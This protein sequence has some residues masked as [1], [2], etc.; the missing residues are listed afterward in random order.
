[1]FASAKLAVSAGLHQVHISADEQWKQERVTVQSDP[2]DRKSTVTRTRLGHR[3]PGEISPGLDAVSH[4]LSDPGAAGRVAP[5]AGAAIM[6]LVLVLLPPTSS[7]RSMLTAAAVLTTIVIAAA[8]LVPWVRLPA[9]C[10]ATV[11]LGFFA[12]VALL[13]QSGGGA[14]SGYSPLVML[15]ILWLAIYGSR[16]QFRLGIAAT[17]VTFVVPQILVG[18]PLYP[19]TGWRGSVIWVTIG[20]LAGSATQKLVD[21]SR[22]RTADV[23]ALGA[24]TRT[25]SANSDPRPELCAAAQLVTGAAFTVLFEPHPDGTLVAT[26][27][28]DG[29][30]VGLRVDPRTHTCATAQAWRTR[31]RI[32][33][34]NAAIDP[35][36]SKLAEHTKARALLCQPVT[37]RGRT[38]ALLAVGF[39]ESHQHAPT[40]ALYLVD[41]LA[42][43]IGAAIDRADMVALLA[44]Q[45]RRDSLTGAANRRSWDEEMNRELAR[46]YR[47]GAPLTIVIIDIDHFKAY[48]DTYGHAAGDELLK[49]LVIA[50]R[51]ELRAGD[52]IARW[53]GEEFALALH[54]C[55]LQEAQTIASRLLSVVPGGQTVSI[56]LTQARAQ[57]TPQALFERADMALYTA[58]NGGRNQ[59]KAHESSP[60]PALF[61]G[62]GVCESAGQVAPVD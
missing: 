47:S 36:S 32:Y 52:V 40:S 56:G 17:A 49:D 30:N 33:L 20:L 9:W 1:M 31:T 16:T 12:V 29:V 43:E 38:K 50:I 13:R 62:H 11:P 54:D 21:A 59:V 48:N 10:Q 24:I 5:F 57:D 45:S 61:H 14:I 51:A 26:A 39:S 19:D 3:E 46:A 4:P 35:H 15:P 34:A 8:L 7:D 23:A 58:K 60:P 37:R 53:G 27:G 41:L 22:H 44:T 55:D 42:A 28:T 6:A 2:V 25:L 18:P